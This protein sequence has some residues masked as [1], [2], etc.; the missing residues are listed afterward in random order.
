MLKRLMDETYDADG[1]LM[2]TVQLDTAWLD[3]TVCQWVRAKGKEASLSGNRALDVFRKRSSVSAFRVAALCQYLYQLE[4]EE[5]KIDH[6]WSMRSGVALSPEVIQKRVRQIY[7][8]MADYIL[9]GMMERWGKRFEE[10]NTKRENE[11]RPGP[12]NILYDQL[13]DTFNREQLRALLE[14]Q[15]KATP[16]KVFLSQWKKL[17]VIEEVDKDTYR[18]VRKEANHD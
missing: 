7:L 2:P 6:A 17:R 3:K 10:L 13:T 5:N 4:A 9:D 18:K 16:V 8:F 14:Q 11:N 12:R 15:G 1:G